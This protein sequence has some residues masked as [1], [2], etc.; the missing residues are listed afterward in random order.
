MSVVSAANPLNNEIKLIT[1]ATSQFWS[2]LVLE[3]QV[4]TMITASCHEFI[5]LFPSKV[6]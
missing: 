5:Y 2:F 4:K 3:H 1:N 6:L